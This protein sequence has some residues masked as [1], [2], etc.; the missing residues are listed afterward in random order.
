MIHKLF[1][2]VT[3]ESFYWSRENM[4]GPTLNPHTNLQFVHLLFWSGSL[5]PFGFHLG[6]HYRQYGQL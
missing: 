3:V 5:S 6:A 4:G 1:L 2:G